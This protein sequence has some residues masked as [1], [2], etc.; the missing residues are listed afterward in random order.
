M[1]KNAMKTIM[2]IIGIIFGVFLVLIVI[3]GLIGSDEETESDETEETTTSSEQRVQQKQVEDE[4]ETTQ[5]FEQDVRD[6]M[7]QVSKTYLMAGDLSDED[8]DENTNVNIIYDT[9]EE[10]EKAKNI[11]Q[12]LQP[13]SEKDEEIY[14]DLQRINILTDRAL[15]N[16]LD[17]YINDDPDK[18]EHATEDINEV[19]EITQNIDMEIN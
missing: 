13:K 8:N 16:V 6:Y 4:N 15:S 9:Q 18:I 1:L 19:G 12:K 17:G 11:Y 3:G 14:K 5:Y 2:G 10:F 7:A